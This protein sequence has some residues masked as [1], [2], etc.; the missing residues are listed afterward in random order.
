MVSILGFPGFLEGIPLGEMRIGI[1]SPFFHF[2]PVWASRKIEKN[3]KKKVSIAGSCMQ[4]F[5]SEAFPLVFTSFSRF[6][7]NYMVVFCIVSSVPYLSSFFRTIMNCRLKVIQPR[8]FAQNPHLRYMWV[9]FLSLK[10]CFLS[11]KIIYYDLCSLTACSIWLCGWV[12]VNFRAE[13]DALDGDWL[14]ENCGTAIPVAHLKWDIHYLPWII[15]FLSA[16]LFLCLGIATS[17]KRTSI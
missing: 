9:H 4:G 6:L 10:A 2:I 17:R 15:G 14:L 8:A 7:Q 1:K 12:K 16:P 5:H 11:S 13:D 3:Q